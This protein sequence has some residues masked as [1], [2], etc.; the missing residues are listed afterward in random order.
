MVR[1]SH[2]LEVVPTVSDRQLCD[3]HKA[4]MACGGLE[5]FSQYLVNIDRLSS[6]R[7][8]NRRTHGFV[9]C[10]RSTHHLHSDRFTSRNE[11][12]ASWY[13]CI[14][15]SIRGYAYF[16]VYRYRLKQLNVLLGLRLGSNQ[17]ILFRNVIQNYESL[18]REKLTKKASFMYSRNVCINDY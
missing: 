3:L 4:M 10:R 2:S 6:A 5:Q 14:L 18:S 9:S 8:L 13:N 16:N 17:K 11:T 15:Y 12:L 7:P 1:Y